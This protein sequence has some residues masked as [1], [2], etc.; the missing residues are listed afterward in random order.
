[1]KEEEDQIGS[2]GDQMKR[3]KKKR[4]GSCFRKRKTFLEENENNWEKL[5]IER[6]NKQQENTRSKNKRKRNYKRSWKESKEKTAQKED[7]C[8]VLPE[9]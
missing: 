1:M 8:G 2:R 6:E 9:T 3:N 5:K 4:A 7:V